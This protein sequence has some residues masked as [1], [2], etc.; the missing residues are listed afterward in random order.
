M[1]N[2]PPYQPK[3]IAF[4]F[5]A[6]LTQARVFADPL[7]KLYADGL[8]KIAEQFDNCEM[9]YTRTTAEGD[10]IVD[11]VFRSNYG[12]VQVEYKYFDDAKIVSVARE[13]AYFRLEQSADSNATWLP[14]R[15][16]PGDSEY[17]PASGGKIEG[18]DYMLRAFSFSHKPLWL[19]REDT[20]IEGWKTVECHE[21]GDDRWELKLTHEGEPVRSARIVLDYTS[22]CRCI[23]QEL[24][25]NGVTTLFKLTYDDVDKVPLIKSV[26]TVVD[27]VAAER[28]DYTWN[29]SRSADHKYFVLE[30][31][32]LSESLLSPIDPHTSSNGTAW[33]A[34]FAVTGGLLLLFA[35]LV[36]SRKKT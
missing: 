23:E 11:G 20:T 35:W 22:V 9:K 34:G 27:G 3:V 30:T 24:R 10:R 32:G 2:R 28:V 12:Q 1:R 21:I 25:F 17:Y 18:P 7:P 5:A 26:E 8:R 31:Y 19:F 4:V 14:R 33:A 6:L 13:G 16:S 36:K 15:L 29:S